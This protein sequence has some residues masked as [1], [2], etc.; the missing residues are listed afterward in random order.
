MVMNKIMF[1]DRVV[2]FKKTMPT[3]NDLFKHI[4]AAKACLSNLS[5]AGWGSCCSWV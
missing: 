5:S 4:L 2:K 1:N 3:S